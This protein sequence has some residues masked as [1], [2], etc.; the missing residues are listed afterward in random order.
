[1]TFIST[2]LFF[3]YRHR[4]IYYVA[5]DYKSGCRQV[6]QLYMKLEGTL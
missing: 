1:M 6:T 5:E 3:V 4:K 2:M